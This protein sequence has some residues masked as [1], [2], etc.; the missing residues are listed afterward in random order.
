[1]SKLKAATLGLLAIAGVGAVTV[2]SA[3]ANTGGHFVS[4]VEHTIVNQSAGATGPHALELSIHGMEGGIVCNQATAQGTAAT[5]T[6]TE[7]IGIITLS[8]CSTT[9]GT[10]MTVTMNG[11]DTRITVGPGEPATTEHTN[12]FI[13][14]AGKKL[15]IHHPNCTIGF[16]P[17]NNLKGFTYTRIVDNGKHAITADVA[18]QFEVQF[19]G[20]ICIF[21][22]TTRVGTI[23]GST[24]V[25]AL[26]TE[27]KQV[28]VTAT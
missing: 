5:S 23:T 21:L 13:C 4:E 7:A 27:G 12:D 10:V 2:M 3:S 22:G 6:V 19:H 17:Q 25:R 8:N 1:M 9:N 24:V 20:G 16:P 15:E 11:C 28:S 26:N 14:P 18:T